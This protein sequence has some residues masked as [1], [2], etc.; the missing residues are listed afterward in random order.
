MINSRLCLA[1]FL[2]ICVAKEVTCESCSLDAASFEAKQ[3]EKNLFVL[4]VK[5]M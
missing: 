2:I 3:K 4:F 1:V 5:D